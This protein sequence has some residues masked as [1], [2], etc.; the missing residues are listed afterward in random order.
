MGKRT[1]NILGDGPREQWLAAIGIYETCITENTR[2]VRDE[3]NY[4]LDASEMEFDPMEMLEIAMK[5]TKNFADE[6]RRLVEGVFE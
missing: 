2:I 5:E 6:M 3:L 1:V 4:G